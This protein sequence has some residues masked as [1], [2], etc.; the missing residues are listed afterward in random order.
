[1]PEE[2]KICCKFCPT[3]RSC[4]RVRTK[5][6]YIGDDLANIIIRLANGIIKGYLTSEDVSKGMD[7]YSEDYKAWIVM[8]R[9]L[10]PLLYDDKKIKKYRFDD[11]YAIIW[12]TPVDC[13]REESDEILRRFFLD[14]KIHL[15]EGEC[16]RTPSLCDDC[17]FCTEKNNCYCWSKD[18][19]QC[20]VKRVT[21][22]KFYNEYRV[23]DLDLNLI[24]EN[25]IDDRTG[26]T[27]SDPSLK[28]VRPFVFDE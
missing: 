27:F 22:V 24:V 21:R 19:C 8:P 10:P 2:T 25:G 12:G 3:K 15:F 28:Y 20:S 11:P 1:M 13:K 18:K 7:I 6:N 9:E 4:C 26:A 16:K 5:K 17:E 14:I 23:W